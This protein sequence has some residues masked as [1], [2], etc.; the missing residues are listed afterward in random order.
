MHLE[1]RGAFSWSVGVREVEFD[2]TELTAAKEG[3]EAATNAPESAP[4]PATEAPPPATTA[5]AK[6]EPV[7]DD[8][9]PLLPLSS[10]AANDVTTDQ[11]RAKEK[12][13]DEKDRRVRE[14]DDRDRQGREI[15]AGL[16]PL[17]VL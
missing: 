12:E 8:R 4:A 6:A 9:P 15:R 13:N 2:M 17:Q 7:V 14:G 5:S 11:N 10:V 3:E 1:A 16:H